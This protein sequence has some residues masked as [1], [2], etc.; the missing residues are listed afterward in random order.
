MT[1]RD[2]QKA[3]QSAVKELED[4]VSA[5]ISNYFNIIILIIVINII[6]TG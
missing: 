4:N 2:L 1:I 5:S 3:F 6:Y